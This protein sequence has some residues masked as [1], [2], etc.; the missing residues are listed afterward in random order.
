MLCVP[1]LLSPLSCASN[2]Y[3]PSDLG[4]KVLSTARFPHLTAIFLTS[5]NRFAQ[6]SCSRA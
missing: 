5:K 3:W 1:V 4:R 6:K 2:T